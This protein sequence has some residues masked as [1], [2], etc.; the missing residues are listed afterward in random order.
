MTSVDGGVL[1]TPTDT[2]HE[3]AKLL[4]W[5]GIDRER[6]SGGGDFRME[7]DVPEA[8]FKF[9]MNDVNAVIGARQPAPRARNAS[10]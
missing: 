2:L 1:A 7:P 5:F 10:L 8:G 3:R 4:R 6:R 9:H